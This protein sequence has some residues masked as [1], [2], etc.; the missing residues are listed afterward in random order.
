MTHKK[1]NVARW[2]APGKICRCCNS[3][4]GSRPRLLKHLAYNSPNC[5][6]FVQ[7]NFAPISDDEVALLDKADLVHVKSNKAA[8][9]PM[10]FAPVPVMKL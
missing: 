6:V 5:L 7:N 9:L 4:F 1:R 3:I 10:T 2:F 8:G